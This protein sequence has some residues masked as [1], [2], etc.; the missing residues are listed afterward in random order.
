MA[1]SSCLIRLS[2]KMMHCGVIEPFRLL[3]VHQA[4]QLINLLSQ[5]PGMGAVIATNSQIYNASCSYDKILQVIHKK[6]I[7][8][9]SGK[10]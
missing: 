1:A 6:L 8:I 3:Q 5:K 2:W 10:R 7:N 4:S 9:V